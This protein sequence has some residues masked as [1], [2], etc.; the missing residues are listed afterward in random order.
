MI[1][2]TRTTLTLALA[3]ALLAGPVVRAIDIKILRDKTVD[4]KQIR[5][6]TWSPELGEVKMMLTAED[7]PEAAKQRLEPVIVQAIE[8]ELPARGYP[9]AASN[10]DIRLTYYVLISAGNNEQVMGQFLPA[11]AM[12][13]LPPFAPQ[14]TSI[15]VI[16]KGSLV[17]DL[18]SI[19]RDMVIW[20]GIAS[21]EIDRAA[22]MEQRVARIRSAVKGLVGKLP[23]R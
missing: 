2:L 8:A 7:N 20:R 3:M 19:Q 16:E 17:M 15:R 4:L 1:R 6:W 5:G 18:A 14:T 21:A 11:N 10:P 9:K 12:W 22:T 13:G 23:K